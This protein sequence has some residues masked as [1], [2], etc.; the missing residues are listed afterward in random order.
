MQCSFGSFERQWAREW[1]ADVCSEW[2]RVFTNYDRFGVTNFS[3]YRDRSELGGKR[4]LTKYV[5]REGYM[6]CL[7]RSL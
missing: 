6:W 7:A 1:R 3:E 4:Q 2:S 5:L